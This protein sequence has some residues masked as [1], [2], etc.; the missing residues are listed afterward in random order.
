M[1][2]LKTISER[3]A[4][5]SECVKPERALGW[6]TGTVR[7]IEH[8]IDLCD[9]APVCDLNGECKLRDSY[10]FYESERYKAYR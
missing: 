6:E 5:Q 4:T 9:E 10:H 7:S 8:A 3:E 1:K 2:L